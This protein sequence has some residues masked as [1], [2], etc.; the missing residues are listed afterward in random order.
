VEKVTVVTHAETG[1]VQV[2]ECYRVARR[3]L[4]T[5]G[6]AYNA[7]GY[8]DLLADGYTVDVCPVQTRLPTV[9]NPA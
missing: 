6:Y 9:V 5:H 8:A 2:F 3:W 4:A 7:Q 1:L